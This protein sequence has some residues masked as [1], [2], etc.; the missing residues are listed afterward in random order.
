M[1][2]YGTKINNTPSSTDGVLTAEEF[3]VLALELE[4]VINS[5]GITLN[6]SVTNQMAKAIADYALAGQHFVDTGAA[7]AYVLTSVG[8]RLASHDYIDGMRVRFFATNTNTGASTVNVQTLGL[9]NIKR[10]DGTALSAGDIT[11]NNYVELIYKTSAGYFI[12]SQ[13]VTISGAQTIFDLKTFNTAPR[14]STDPSNASDLVR[15]SYLETYVASLV[16]VPKGYV[17]GLIISNNGTD[18]N[19]DID[20]AAGTCASSD[21][22]YSLTLGSTMTKRLDAAWAAG[23]NQGGLFSGAGSKTLNTWYHVFLIRKTSDGTI[24]VGFDTSL[25]AA[26]MPGTYNAYRRVGSVLTDASNNIRAFFQRGGNGYNEFL[27]SAPSLDISGAYAASRSL[28]TLPVPLGVRCKAS[29][30]YTHDGEPVVN[31]T[32]SYWTDPSMTDTA[33]NT[34]Q[35][36]AHDTSPL[37]I[38]SARHVDCWTNTSSQVGYRPNYA[39][40]LRA[41]CYSYLDFL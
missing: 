10:P 8:S 32:W 20:V 24:D 17:N 33:P 40:T 7:D 2:D 19:N 13:N 14:A 27:W 15:K 16:T 9:K 28:L 29:I 11:A 22:A 26:N 34:T 6:G 18:P 38:G 1:Y 25:T 37:T 21:G 12:L 31:A 30:L 23:T 36:L 5:M 3:N 41:R 4:T 35:A 39:V